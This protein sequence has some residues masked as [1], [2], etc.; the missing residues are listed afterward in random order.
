MAWCV[1][2]VVAWFVILFTG[3]YP[4]GL[5]PF[6]TGALRWRLRVEASLLLMVDA[7]PRFSLD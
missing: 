4:R 3:A 1:A 7:N 2:T 5:V 6:S